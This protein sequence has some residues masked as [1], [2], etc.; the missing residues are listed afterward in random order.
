MGVGKGV[1]ARACHQR[2]QPSTMYLLWTLASVF[3][4]M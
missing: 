1:S 4:V 2:S 3:L